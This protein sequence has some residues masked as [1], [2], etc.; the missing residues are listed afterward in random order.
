MNPLSP[1]PRGS[2]LLVLDALLL[3]WVLL[4]LWL[5]I[6]VGQEVSGLAQLSDRVTSTGA[7]IEAVGAR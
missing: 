4:W 1:L 7:A 6:R 3:L 2:R 5:G